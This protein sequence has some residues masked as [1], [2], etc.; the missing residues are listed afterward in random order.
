MGEE[1]SMSPR[2]E[3]NLILEVVPH[4]TWVPVSGAGHLSPLEAPDT[5]ASALVNLVV[6]DE[7]IEI[8]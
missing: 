2:D 3:Q 8:D 5:V 4:A 6:V 7:R 1:D